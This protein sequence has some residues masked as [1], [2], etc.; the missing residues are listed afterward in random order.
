MDFIITQEQNEKE[1]SISD[2]GLTP[3]KYQESNME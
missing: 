2:Q 1:L 3:F